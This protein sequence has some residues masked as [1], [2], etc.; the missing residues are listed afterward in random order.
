MLSGK[1]ATSDSN[2]YF[3]GKVRKGRNAM[4]RLEKVTNVVIILACAFLIGTLARN[5]YL[6]RKPDPRIQ[7]GIQK[8]AVVKLP[9]AASGNQQPAMPT[10]V[11]ALSKNCHFCQESVGFYQKITALK[12]SSPQGLRL[13][14]V[15][16][17]SKE[18]AASYLKEQGIGVDE[19]VSMEISKLGLRGT[20]TLLLLDGQNKLEE[21]WVGKLNDSQE[22]QVMTRLK[23]VCAGCSLQKTAMGLRA[24]PEG[25]GGN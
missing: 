1:D 11:L 15:L 10:L 18:E 14:A 23:Q 17:Q 24:G 4:N 6:S 9:G 16:P 5:Y 13:V 20:P 21:L 2:L 7:P 8:G 22:E 19:V 3:Q 12:N 25:L